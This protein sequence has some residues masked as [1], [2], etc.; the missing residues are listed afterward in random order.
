MSIQAMTR[1]WADSAAGG[2]ELLVLLAIANYAKADGT[3]AWPSV[4][5]LAADARVS[6]RSV[7][8][9]IQRLEG[10]GELRIH[11]SAGPGGAHLY[12]VLPIDIERPP[13][14]RQS[15]TPDE[16][17]GGCQIDRGGDILTGDNLT[18][19]V[20]QPCHGGG[21][22]A[23]SPNPSLNRQLQQQQQQGRAREEHVI[24]DATEVEAT[25]VGYVQQIR[26]AAT[27]PA[28]R[29]ILQLRE[30]L[31]IRREPIDDEAL[32]YE[33]AKFRDYWSDQRSTRPLADEWVG[34]RKAMTNWISRI[35]RE[36]APSRVDRPR[37]SPPARGRNTPDY[38]GIAAVADVIRA[39][40]REQGR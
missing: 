14:G 40:E 29:I 36:A 8:R 10:R 16:P 35:P 15:V 26:G 32:L 4:R 28:G 17:I 12:D 31:Q 13:Q 30:A 27:I 21:D 25:I 11:R 1:V 39:R 20:T 34:W 18:G 23:M 22:I 33:M 9:I 24:S 7:Q 19:G 5:T 38:S 3:G 6:P 2:S 37:A